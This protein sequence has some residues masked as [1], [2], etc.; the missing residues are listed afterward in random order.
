MSRRLSRPML[1]LLPA[2][3]LLAGCDVPSLPSVGLPGP[4]LTGTVAGESGSNL[5]VGLL[6]TPRAGGDKLELV[7]SSVSS[8]GS[9]RL[10]LPDTPR[11]DMMVNDNESVLFTL[12]AYK[13][14]NGNG[15]FDASDEL[16]DA[17][18]QAGTFRYFAE[19]G[20][21]GG[22]KAGWNLYKDGTYVQSFDTAFVLR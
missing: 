15:R 12:S 5:R 11:M 16:T 9:Y 20:A 14:L 13:D 10:Q 3:A 1:T 4:T 7:S 17:A 19:D 2:L 8:G 18:A 6:G 22:Y 21:P